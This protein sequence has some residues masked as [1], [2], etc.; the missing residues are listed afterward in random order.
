MDAFVS[1]DFIVFLRFIFFCIQR[2]VL[3]CKLKLVEREHYLVFIHNKIFFLFIISFCFIKKAL[4]SIIF[5]L[6]LIKNFNF[7]R[8]LSDCL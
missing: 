3:F 1:G 4:I 7:C 8:V 6:I 5:T 2:F